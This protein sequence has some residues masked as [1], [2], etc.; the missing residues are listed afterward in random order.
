MKFIGVLLLLTLSVGQIFACTETTASGSYAPAPGFCAG[1]LIFEDNFNTLDLNRWKHEVTLSGMGN[2]EFQWYVNDRTNSYVTNGV[3]HIRPT[4]TSDVFGEGF[5]SSGRVIIPPSECTISWDSGC[6][7]QGTPDVIINPIRSGKIMSVDSFRFKYGALEVRAKLPAGDWLW[8][9]LWMMP[10]DNYVYGNWPTGGEIDLMESRGNRGLYYAGLNFGTEQV[11]ST[12]HFGPSD[13]VMHMIHGN[14]N[15]IPSFDENFHVYRVEWRSSGFQFFYDGQ[16]V[17]TIP[18]ENGFW[19][20]GGF[21]SSG[22]S[23]PWASGTLMAPFDQEFYIQMNLAVGSNTGYFWDGMDNRSGPRPWT[24]GQERARTDFWN[25]RGQ[26]EPTWNLHNED[27]H[28]QIDY[29]R[30]YAL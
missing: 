30:V 13:S 21:A 22:L 2:G 28:F 14:Q 20:K 6:D 9:A 7:R 19:E 15:R 23:N 17:L 12:I 3:Y 18:V 27:R 11:G 16:H 8:P 10:Y 29:V 4:Y 26:W 5:L 24:N 1:D 25:G